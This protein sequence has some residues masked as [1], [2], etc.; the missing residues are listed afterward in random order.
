[1]RNMIEEEMVELDGFYDP[2]CDGCQKVLMYLL[3]KGK[4]PNHPLADRARWALWMRMGIPNTDNAGESV[5]GQLNREVRPLGNFM[6]RLQKVIEH[7]RRRYDARGVW[8]DE[9]LIRNV[10]KWLPPTEV[11]ANPFDAARREFYVRL[12]NAQGLTK[13]KKRVPPEMIEELRVPEGCSVIVVPDAL[14]AKWVDQGTSGTEVA[15]DPAPEAA[16]AAARGITDEDDG[17]RLSVT[18][19]SAL[20]LREKLAYRL[21]ESVRRAIGKS[22][23]EKA[24]LDILSIVLK[25]ADNLQLPLDDQPSATQEAKWRASVWRQVHER[26]KQ[27][28]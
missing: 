15:P 25:E 6:E 20:H 22:E 18:E 24:S 19:R 8:I 16:P 21:G 17:R 2:N 13:A 14:P 7:L 4:D 10:D 26:L 11:S 28:T 9:A 1:M 23:W 27:S 5:H 12:H 3:G